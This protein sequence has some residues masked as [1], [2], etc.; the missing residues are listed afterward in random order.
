MQAFVTIS[1][2]QFQQLQLPRCCI[3]RPSYAKCQAIVWK[4]IDCHLYSFTP[5]STDGSGAQGQVSSND[6]Y[7]Y[8]LLS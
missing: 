4:A 7:V 3:N 5:V 8:V 2:I 1:M 6:D